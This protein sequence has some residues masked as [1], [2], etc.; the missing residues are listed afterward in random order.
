MKRLWVALVLLGV[1][2]VLFLGTPAFSDRVGGLTQALSKLTRPD[3]QRAIEKLGARFTDN[4]DGTV[5]DNLTGLVWMKHASDKANFR[6]FA[7]QTSWAD[8]CA[9]CNAL[10]DGEHGLTDGSHPGDWRLP[11]VRELQSLIDYSQYT[12][13][14]PAG[15]P[16]LGVHPFVGEGSSNYWSSTTEP[17]LT[18]DW[19]S[20]WAVS[21]DY[22]DAFVY[23]K[24][25]DGYYVW[26]VRGGQ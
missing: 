1:S 19:A 13:P 16:F 22:G 8:A 26:C 21:F 10:E 4:E 6:G 2:L 3:L 11:N 25:Y 15:H 18:G 14:L 24:S 23:L 7:A 17:S 20:A 9:A 5:T 12:P